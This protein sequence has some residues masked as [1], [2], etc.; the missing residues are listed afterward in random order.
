MAFEQI[1]TLPAK[2]QEWEQGYQAASEGNSVCPYSE[3]SEE[4][5]MWHFGFHAFALLD[6]KEA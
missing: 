5:A 6:E 3:D 4:W 1:T 2:S